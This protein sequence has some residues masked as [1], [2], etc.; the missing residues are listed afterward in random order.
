MLDFYHTEPDEILALFFE[1]RKQSI[2]DDST[3]NETINK[4]IESYMIQCVEIQDA[5]LPDSEL[6]SSELGGHAT[7]DSLNGIGVGFCDFYDGAPA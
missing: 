5:E 2:N 3:I 7:M 1:Y 4:V 6:W